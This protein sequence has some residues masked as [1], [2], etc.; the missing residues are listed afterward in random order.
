MSLKGLH[1]NKKVAG[2]LVTLACL[3][4]LL[5]LLTF[6]GFP[7]TAATIAQQQGDDANTA[8]SNAQQGEREEQKH[9]KDKEASRPTHKHTAF[10]QRKEQRNKMV[11]QQ[12]EGRGVSDRDVLQAM[13]TVPR[14]AFVLK[15]DSR[16]AYRDHPLPIGLGQTISQPYIVAYMT[17]ALKLGPNSKVLEIGTG[18]GY[19]A[20]VC[21]EIADEVFTIEILEKLAESAKK[22][23]AE[24]GYRNVYA[25]AGDGYFGWPENG[26]FDAI[27]ITAAAGMI[28]PPLIEQLKPGGRM[29]LPLGSPYGVQTLVLVTKNA[30]GRV[31][32]RRLI[33]VRF[34]PMIGKVAEEKESRKK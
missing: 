28:P 8:E 7:G 34:V 11:A 25:K 21:A 5:V 12:I 32:T 10:G 4:S 18:S 2:I 30:E 33:A 27:I 23:L 1:T 17:E 16:R 14:H 29:I 31:N 24:L 22:R 19:Q 20:A 15:Q 3:A 9:K 13:R 26:P 6:R